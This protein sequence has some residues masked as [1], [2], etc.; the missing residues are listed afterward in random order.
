[1]DADPSARAA[2]IYDAL[3]ATAL[4]MGVPGF[5]FATGH[6]LIQADR[7]IEYLLDAAGPPQPKPPKYPLPFPAP[8]W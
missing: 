5:D 3:E 7:A 8:W 4:D 1:M 6:G 2:Q